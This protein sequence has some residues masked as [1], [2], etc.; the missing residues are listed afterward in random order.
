[1]YYVWIFIKKNYSNNE[2]LN[3]SKASF[4]EFVLPPRMVRIENRISALTHG[5]QILFIGILSSVV[6]SDYQAHVT[7]ISNDNNYY[8]YKFTFYAIRAWDTLE[9]VREEIIVQLVARYIY[10]HTRAR[11]V[12][13]T[14]VD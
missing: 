12:F 1:V 13:V 2:R 11:T 9:I 14:I 6:E 5:I 10:C 3:H 4:I 8:N 7:R